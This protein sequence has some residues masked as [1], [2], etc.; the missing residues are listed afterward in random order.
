M[1]ATTKV[2]KF[3]SGRLVANP[4]DLSDP[5]NNCGGTQLGT[6]H[7]FRLQI[8][9]RSDPIIAEEWGMSP[10]DHVN[11][12][13]EVIAT[14]SFTG[15][16]ENAMSRLFFNSSVSSG[17]GT[18]RVIDTDSAYG[19]LGS[20]RRCIL[21]WLPNDEDN[22]PAV[23]IYQAIPWRIHRPIYFS[24]RKAAVVEASWICTRGSANTVWV[25]DLL[26]NL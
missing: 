10:N 13:S 22:N 26:E 2:H 11:L 9:R 1:G 18:P 3:S 25:S 7:N 5:A 17:N 12:D 15:W 20:D 19:T 16:D 6:V 14:A 23:Y 8:T 4:T 21:L 24:G